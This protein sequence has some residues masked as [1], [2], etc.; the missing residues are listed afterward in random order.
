MAKKISLTEV[1]DA[2]HEAKDGD[3]ILIDD[4]LGTIKINPVKFDLWKS[5][6]NQ[7]FRGLK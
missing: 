4:N 6:N 1:I 2:Y 5:F 7:K 3:M